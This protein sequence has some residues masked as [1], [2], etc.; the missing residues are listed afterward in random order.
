M[1][2]R[3]TCASDA[4]AAANAGGR[5]LGALRDE[6]GIDHGPSDVVVAGCLGHTLALRGDR[7]ASCVRNDVISRFREGTAATTR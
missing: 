3:A 6:R 2:L 7:A 5:R 1:S 4:T